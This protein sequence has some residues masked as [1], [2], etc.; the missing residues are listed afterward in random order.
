MKSECEVKT[1]KPIKHC[2]T[3]DKNEINT[4]QLK[5]SPTQYGL[6]CRECMLDYTK[7]LNRN[8]TD[9]D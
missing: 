9:G 5:L 8:Q 7:Y 6:L 4:P 1:M 2:D 3:C